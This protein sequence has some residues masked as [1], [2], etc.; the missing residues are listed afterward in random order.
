MK[1]IIFNVG[2]TFSLFV[3]DYGPKGSRVIDLKRVSSFLVF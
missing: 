2:R 3:I 1:G